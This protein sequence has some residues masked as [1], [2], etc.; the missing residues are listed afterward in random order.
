M[1]LYVHSAQSS[2]VRSSSGRAGPAPRGKPPPSLATRADSEGCQPELVT[3]RHG[4]RDW[5]SWQA[6]RRTEQDPRRRAGRRRQTGPG[7]GRTMTRNATSRPSRG[8]GAAGGCHGSLASPPRQLPVRRRLGQIPGYML[9]V[10]RRLRITPESPRVHRPLNSAPG[11]L[12]LSGNEGKCSQWH[13]QPEAASG[14]RNSTEC[15]GSACKSERVSASRIC[16]RYAIH[17]SRRPWSA[18]S[19][20]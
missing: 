16:L 17:Q 8:P 9:V 15:T 5:H 2:G 13:A 14:I 11:S 19:I 3:G 6:C 20:R 12:E 18:W 1:L 7:N 10:A 4:H